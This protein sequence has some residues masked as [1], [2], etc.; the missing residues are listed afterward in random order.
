MSEED[1]VD[2]SAAQDG[3]VKKHIVRAAP[4]DAEKPQAKY[5]CR[6][7]YTGTLTETSKSEK[8]KKKKKKKE[9]SNRQKRPSSIRR[10]RATSR[11]AFRSDKAK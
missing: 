8:K 7:H 11:L 3:G 9:N 6:V 1:W 5:K 10:E 2:V 4:D